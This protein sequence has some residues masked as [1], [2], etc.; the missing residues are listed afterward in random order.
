MT[1]RGRLT[2]AFL[3]VV[4]GPV[5]LGA[6][7]VAGTMSQVGHQRAVERLE[8]A[9]NA[10]RTSV[11]ALCRQLHGAAD[12]IAVTA[13][14]AHRAA[15][16]RQLV[17]RG[18]AAAIAITDPAG[19]P[20]LTSPEQPVPQ[21]LD[22][23][24]TGPAT[25]GAQAL[26]VRVEL[27][28]GTGTVT[29]SV[30]A[31]QPVDPGFVARLSGVTGAAVT[32]LTDT[33][34]PPTA[35]QTTEADDGR[36]EVLA[37]AAGLRGDGIAEAGNGRYVRRVGPDAE[38]P[39]PL[40]LSVPGDAAQG[41]SAVLIGAVLLAAL[42]AVLAARAL[43]RSTT[44]PLDD[45]AYAVELVAQGDLTARVPVSSGDEIGRLAATFNRM[46]RETQSYVQALT[47]SRDQLR[48]HLAVLGDMLASTH[49][50]HRHPAGDP[51]QRARRHRRAGR[52]GAAGRP[53]QRHPRRPVRRRVAGALAAS[54]G[55]HRSAGV[56]AGPARHPG[57]DRRR[58]DRPGRGHRRTPARP[59]RPGPAVV[60]P[61]TG[62]R[63]VRGGALHRPGGGDRV[64]RARAAQRLR[65]AGAEADGAR[66]AGP[67]RPARLRRVRRRGPAHAAAPSPG[68][69]PWRWRTSGCTRRCSG[70]R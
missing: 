4:L 39:L 43:A 59:G 12:T 20:V 44:R 48:G 42:L 29:G 2:A 31:L 22:C 66:G 35:A 65:R 33:A 41:R 38:Q 7:F 30:I 56:P 61:G 51:A 16:V 5:L 11:G 47:G 54:G 1:L 37:T 52:P 60:A 19:R 45:L 8:L 13:D 25:G 62:L 21:W 17:G 40:V 18:V 57:A 9:A 3:A 64:R 32:L 68:T 6:F 24:A 14:P 15:A 28:D 26:G 46:T 36:D 50:L 58:R 10:A 53:R 23:A 67:L 63:D 69:P 49:D 70:C 27:R 34:G 55:P